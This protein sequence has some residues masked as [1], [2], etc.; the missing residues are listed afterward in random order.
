M[1]RINSA[2]PVKAL[3]DE[4]LLAEHREIKRICAQFKSSILEGKKSVKI[5]ERF[6]LGTGHVTFFLDKGLFTFTRYRAIYTE[7]KDRGFQ[8]EDYSANWDIYKETPA[9]YL[10]YQCT[11]EEY[12]LLKERILERIGSS[13][14][15]TFHYYSLPVNKERAAEILGITNNE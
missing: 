1:T 14:K 9:Y 4:H 6:T 10:D 11:K 13:P 15:A 8:V 7:C 3:T 5:P 12:L 2:I